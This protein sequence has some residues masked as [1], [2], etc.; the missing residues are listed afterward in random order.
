MA[1]SPLT[2]VRTGNERRRARS[3][4]STQRSTSSEATSSGAPAC[5]VR[6]DAGL[7]ALPLS[8]LAEVFFREHS[9]DH[10][11]ANQRRTGSDESSGSR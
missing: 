8:R 5:L 9:P 2:M 4:G 10:R 7:A 3:T 6:S 1:D 11:R